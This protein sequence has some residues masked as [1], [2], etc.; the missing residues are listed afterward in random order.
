MLR[1]Q[2][3]AIAPRDVRALFPAAKRHTYLNAA[4][5]SPL[6][7][8][9]S[10]AVEEHLRDTVENG[11]LSFSK[12]LALKETLR[13]RV[14]RFMGAEA[15]T[16]G[17]LPS[18]SMGFSVIGSLLKSKGITEVLTLE[19]EFPS[20]TLPLLH[21]GLTL[22]VVKRKGDGSYPVEAIE[23]AITP[24]TGAVALSAVQYSSGYRVDLAQI[25][26]LCQIRGLK[27]A[28]NAAQSL[29]QVP[30][31]VASLGADFLCAPSHKWM[32]GGYGVGLFY[33]RKDWHDAAA[34]PFGGWLSVADAD[35]FSPF[36]GA[37]RIDD[38]TGFLARG[39][40][41]KAEPSS[42]EAGSPAW[43]TLFALDAAMT[44]HEGVS[45]GATRAHIVQLQTKLRAALRSKGYEPNAP[46]D[47]P[48]LS[49]ICTVGVNGDPNEAVRALAKAGVVT[50]SRGGG[51]RISTHVFNDE[52]DFEKLFHALQTCGIKPWGR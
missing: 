5:S 2:V 6:A 10:Q 13:G 27:L 21:R 34:W 25:A 32:M 46:D 3:M 28:V 37:Q 9:V 39:T 20:T 40:R 31:N 52:E 16:I 14:A 41:M 36:V 7:E 50:T 38:G 42:L 44:I 1:A 19:G 49:G 15:S 30:I 12:W 4:A 47:V 26:A 45:V 22:K 8:P 35:L 18:T 48:H 51:L 17:F 11:D 43:S 23:A 33:A 24:L 29:G